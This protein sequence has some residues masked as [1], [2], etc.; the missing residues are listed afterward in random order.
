VTTSLGALAPLSLLAKLVAV[1]LGE[2]IARLR[3]PFPET[4][5]VTSTSVQVPAVTRPEEPATA[6]KDGLLL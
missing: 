4:S 6:P 5:P 2:V 3:R 1:E